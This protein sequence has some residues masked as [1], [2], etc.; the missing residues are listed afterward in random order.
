MPTTI[1]VNPLTGPNYKVRDGLN[2]LTTG[3]TLQ[4]YYDPI[5][6]TNIITYDISEFTSNLPQNSNANYC[7]FFNLGLSRFFSASGNTITDISLLG[8][9]G[10][11][12]AVEI[13]GLTRIYSGNKDG[14]YGRPIDYTL[15]HVTLDFNSTDVEYI[16]QGGD[17]SDPTANPVTGLYLDN[18]VFTGTHRGS[19][20][21]NRGAYS[22][23]VGANGLFFDAV[24][25]AEDFGTQR[26]Y[27]AGGVDTPTQ[28]GSGFLFAQ[29]DDIK[30]RDCIFNENNYETSVILWGSSMIE[31]NGNTFMGGLQQKQ[32]G[33]T[34]SNS[35]GDV[36]VNKFWG[37]SFLTVANAPAG[38]DKLRIGGNNFTSTNDGSYDNQDSTNSVKSVNG[39]RFE[40]IQLSTDPVTY[41]QSF[42]QFDQVVVQDNTFSDVVPLYIKNITTGGTGYNARAANGGA[43]TNNF[44]RRPNLDNSSTNSLTMG[45]M[46]VGAG[47][48][49]T[50]QGALGGSIRDL[51]IGAEGND[52]LRGG[53]G[54]D[55]FM[56]TVAP[57][58][59]T[60][61]DSITDYASG[62][63]IWLDD[64]VFTALP[65][66]G[67]FSPNG[68]TNF[69]RFYSGTVSNPSLAG[70]I[71][72]NTNSKQLWYDP[73]NQ[74]RF[75][76]AGV[77]LI[78]QLQ[79]GAPNISA[80]DLVVF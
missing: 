74:G 40:A 63:Q 66:K 54:S 8:N 56:F 32:L 28:G 49:D 57:N 70:T 39:I 50:L 9:T 52:T 51:I 25:V 79:T 31:V 75:S 44:L 26:T 36:T 71:N 24:T 11:S 20:T 76:G 64:S 21:G 22:S 18:V 80:S 14:G 77:E 30:V 12:S 5:D 43:S 60:N 72:F 4:L 67:L 37:G 42:A 16:L 19:N 15:S 6:S 10:D 35:T 34:I 23:L 78:C 13:T 41:D 45:N 38:T 55:V 3:D 1:S 62:E 27:V 73:S 46:I 69:N 58:S 68:A 2:L 59:T 47:G 48:D 17:Y 33:Q 29:G 53:G 65:G 7:G 61:W